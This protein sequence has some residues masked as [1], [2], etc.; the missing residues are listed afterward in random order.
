MVRECSLTIHLCF[1]WSLSSYR[2]RKW[3]ILKLGCSFAHQTPIGNANRI[4]RFLYFPAAYHLPPTLKIELALHHILFWKI[5]TLVSSKNCNFPKSM[6]FVY[7]YFLIKMVANCWKCYSWSKTLNTF[8]M[9]YYK[10]F[11]FLM[12][13]IKIRTQLFVFFGPKKPKRC[14]AEWV[15]SLSALEKKPLVDTDLYI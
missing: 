15:R 5:C 6:F 4:L 13:T 9:V 11:I 7:E 14:D 1:I 3:K 10:I 2:Q 12:K 8:W